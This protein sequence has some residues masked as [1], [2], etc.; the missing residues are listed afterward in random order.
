MELLGS[1]SADPDEDRGKSLPTYAMSE[2]QLNPYPRVR[3]WIGD[4]FTHLDDSGSLQW[5]LIE[6]IRR[7]KWILKSA[8]STTRVLNPL[9]WCLQPKR[10]RVDRRARSSTRADAVLSGAGRCAGAGVSVLV[11]YENDDGSRSLL[12]H[13]RSSSGVSAGEAMYHVAPAGMFQSFTG[14]VYA[15][16]SVDLTA[17][18]EYLEELFGLDTPQRK[19]DI[20]AWVRLNPNTRFLQA[21]LDSGK[22]DL[23][24]TGIALNLLTLTPEVLGLLDIRT[25]D[26][27]RAHTA[28]TTDFEGERLADLELNEE[29][30]RLDVHPDQPATDNTSLPYSAVEEE[31][32]AHPA[33]HPATIWPTGAA[34]VW[35]GIDALRAVDQARAKDGGVAK[36][37]Q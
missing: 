25:S 33:L 4:Y 32:L 12:V 36:P 14:S 34:A 2:I 11:R 37:P 9:M 27:K 20:A 35:A 3:C 17:K 26:W 1:L 31:L 21:L 18:R 13:R 29:Y 8:P 15:D 22:A 16:Y 19:L 7:F 28:P 10:M 24:Y 23:R 6:S 30:A 5:E